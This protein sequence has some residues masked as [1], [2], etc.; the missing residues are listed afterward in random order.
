MSNLDNNGNAGDVD[1]A[2]I[3]HCTKQFEHIEIIAQRAVDAG[4]F[5]TLDDATAAIMRMLNTG[6]LMG[7]RDNDYKIMV[8]EK[9]L[10]P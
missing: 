10:M 1:Q 5:L 6:K 3:R 9:H 8:A 4:D 7:Q 2:I